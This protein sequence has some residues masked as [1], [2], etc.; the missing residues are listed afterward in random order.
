MSEQSGLEHETLRWVKK[1][2]DLVLEQSG[3]SLQAYVEDED[4]T[5]YLDEV[6][7]SLRQVVGTLQMVEL[8]GASMLAEEMGSLT[9]ALLNGKVKN[10]D[11]AIEVLFR[12]ILQLPD[13]LEHIQSGNRDV[14]IVLLPLLNDLRTSRD[15]PLL[16]EAV[17]FFPQ[18]DT[19]TAPG[20]RIVESSGID[21]AQVLAKRLRHTFQLGLLGL[22]RN[23][24]VESSLNKLFSVV[25]RIHRASKTQAGQRLWWVASALPE[26]LANDALDPNVTIKSLLGKVDRQIKTLIDEGEAAFTKRSSDDL[27]KNILYYL[28]LAEFRGPTVKEVK[29]AFSLDQLIPKD[30]DLSEVR[31]NLAAPNAELLETVSDALNED[32]AEVKDGLEIFISSEESQTGQL[33]TVKEK[34]NRIADTLGMLGLGEAREEVLS[35][36]G[37]LDTMDEGGQDPTDS[38]IMDMA[39][40]MIKIESAIGSL[41]EP[42]VA[43]PVSVESGI[44]ARPQHMQGLSDAEYKKMLDSVVQEAL[45]EMNIT[46][47]AVSDFLSAPQNSEQL[48]LVPAHLERIKGV[49]SVVN[50]HDVVPLLDSLGRYVRGQLLTSRIVP[51][52]RQLEA[53]ADAIT[54][55][56]YFLESLSTHGLD[57]EPIL[58][59]GE[60]SVARLGYPLGGAADQG[61]VLDV[62][63]Y[64]PATDVVDTTVVEIDDLVIEPEEVLSGVH[65]IPD[66][67]DMTLESATSAETMV[68]NMDFEETAALEHATEKTETKSMP[69]AAPTPAPDASGID[70]NLKALTGEIDDEILEIFIEEA[71]EET[72]NIQSL[73]PQWRDDN[74]QEALSTIRRSFHTLKGS[75][76]LVGAQLLG[77]FAWGYESL[78]NRVIDQTIDLQPHIYEAIAD[79]GRVLPQLV[80]QIKGEDTAASA[81]VFSMMEMVNAMAKPGY[82]HAEYTK[83]KSE[84]NASDLA[85]AEPA[86]EDADVIEAADVSTAPEGV[87]LESV[88]SDTEVAAD[89]AADTVL[90]TEVIEAAPMPTSQDDG[91]PTGEFDTDALGMTDFVVPEITE[92]IEG[93]VSVEDEIDPVLLEI[94]TNEARQHWVTLDSIMQDGLRAGGDLDITE[95][96]LR[97][98][99]TL[100]GSSR[101]AEVD[102]ISRLCGPLERYLRARQQ[103]EQP[104]VASA[105]P[106][107]AECSQRIAECIDALVDNKSLPD[108]GALSVQVE[109]LLADELDA[110]NT[111][112]DTQIGKIL[113]A[114][115]VELRQQAAAVETVATEEETVSESVMPEAEAAYPDLVPDMPGEQDQELVEIFL[116][117]AHEILDASDNSLQH[118]ISSSDDKDAMNELQRQLHTLKGGARMAGFSSIGDLSHATESLIVS[119]ADGLVPFSTDMASSLHQGFDRLHEMLQKASRQEPV[120]PAPDIISRLDEVRKGGSSTAAETVSLQESI[121]A[122]TIE[123]AERRESQAIAA[124]DE[125]LLA[126]LEIVGVE[127]EVSPDD[128]L[129]TGVGAIEDSITVEDETVSTVELEAVEEHHEPIKPVADKSKGTAARSGAQELVRVRSDLLDNLVNYAGEV[130]IYHSR[131]AQQIN[132]Y[133]FNLNELEQTLRRLRDQLR[134]MELETEAQILFRYEQEHGEGD[135]E[136]DPLELDRYSN[137]QQLSRGLAETANDL[138]SIRDVMADIVRDSETLMLQQSRVSTDLQEG[139]MRTRMVQFSGMAPRLRR[140]ARQTANELGR[141]V[142]LHISGEHN[143]IDRNVLDRMVAPLEHM[144]R[145]AISHGIETP[146]ERVQ[147]GKSETGIIHINISRDGGEIVINCEDDGTGINLGK[148][149]E[150]ALAAGMLKAEDDVSD[151]DAMQLIL[152]SGFSTADK[153]TQISGR[154]VGMDVVNNEIKQLGGSLTIDSV[155]GKGTDFV[156]R[157]P[158]TLAIN[159]ALLVQTGEDL[160]AV[161]LGSIEGVVR[162]PG[163]ELA[164]SYAEENPIHQYAGNEY[165]L[166]HLGALLG[167][168]KPMLDESGTMYPVLLVRSGDHRFALQAEEL[169]GSREIVVKPVGPQISK[170]RGISGAT[171]LGDGRVVLILDVAGL[172]RISVAGQIVYQPEE[173]AVTKEDQKLTVMVIDDSITIRKVTTRMLERNNYEVITA[174]DGVDAVSQLHELTPDLMLLDIEMPR[175]D[176]YELATHVRNNERLKHIPIIMITSRT[177][178]KHRKRAMDIGVNRYLGKPYQE[179]DL[180][181]NIEKTLKDVTEK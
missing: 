157:L 128:L 147:K 151:H 123:S 163:N 57:P 180:L 60:A 30:S 39:G 166:K 63:D 178:E 177:G 104:V 66:F 136:F 10:K 42:H 93:P 107:F 26:A 98:I 89:F 179:T 3:K 4:K 46:K 8:Y 169:I 58:K 172:V 41:R 43:P 12:A 144:L 152:E 36:A 76:R 181:E 2:L 6:K 78:L 87:D 11:D 150:K 67:S 17:L 74:D 50:I 5:A 154:G 168:S 171:I 35:E 165:E 138:G 140:I 143:E 112:P 56:E 149:R 86:R 20:A 96:L 132:A 139:L 29:K 32:L 102:E 14:P 94:F 79:A 108:S 9:Q 111:D 114:E 61:G 28:A 116:E 109:A 113:T 127:E 119:C 176:G 68:D 25:A 85:T 69:G 38:A 131:L 101:T 1:E 65:D 115:E 19:V 145:N 73:L 117:E 133:S 15:A 95:P 130:N 110:Q 48:E 122:S 80:A 53:F 146:Q 126:D 105:V 91:P 173:P 54:S 92:V 47:D 49:M 156:V 129:V 155:F 52:T 175:M 100:N 7:D 77:E 148:I 88:Q 159:Q 135:E 51:D 142:A 59:A 81:D 137:I 44:A 24:N 97:S 106:L 22:F 84:K 161:P 118:W 34:L 99:H 170:V 62:E 72:N 40:V 158:F 164:S 27:I 153:V 120:Y 160:Y 13:Y 125:P 64:E 45:H 174:K 141:K 103:I 121:E 55:V 124:D 82:S 31:D 75:G 167:V 37:R 21:D 71:E 16:S 162:L 23:Q 18:F 33:N 90:E 134:K 83:K 70:R